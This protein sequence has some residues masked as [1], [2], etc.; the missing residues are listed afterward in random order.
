M[1]VFQEPPGVYSDKTEIGEHTDG[2][3]GGENI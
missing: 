3:G 2:T 1:E